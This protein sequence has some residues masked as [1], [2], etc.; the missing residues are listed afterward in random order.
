MNVLIVHAHPESASFTSSMR[1]AAVDTLSADGHHVRVSDLYQM[2]FNPVASENDFMGRANED[3]LVYALEQ[4]NADSN[5][6]LSPDINAEIEK[7]VWAD[8]VIFN[9]P[10]YWFSMP[11]I[12]KGW[13]DRVFVSGRFYGGMRFYDRGGLRG[14]KALVSVTLGGQPH[15]FD[16]D[17]VHGPLQEMLRHLLRG[18]LGY[19]GFEVLPPFIGWHVPYISGEARAAILDEYRACLRSIDD[20]ETM[21]FPS[22]GDFDETLRPKTLKG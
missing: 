12:M 7:V 4:R 19:L 14:K 20:L 15:M 10:I 1:D 13:V 9:F 6:L 11:A 16:E 3:Y 18:T 21:K 8:L 2:D 17:G 22:L 5:G